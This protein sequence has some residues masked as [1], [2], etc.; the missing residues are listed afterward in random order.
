[1]YS[2]PPRFENGQVLT[3][4]SL[5]RMFDWMVDALNEIAEH[6]LQAEHAAE[7][8]ALAAERSIRLRDDEERS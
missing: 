8:A 3:A 5:N 7:R 4:E 1:V 6:R 2:R